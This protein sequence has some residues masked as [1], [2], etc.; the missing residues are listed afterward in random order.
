VSDQTKR[1]VELEEVQFFSEDVDIN[2][3]GFAVSEGAFHGYSRFHKDCWLRSPNGGYLMQIASLFE[4][5]KYYNV[6]IEFEEVQ[7]TEEEGPAS[8]DSTNAKGEQ[9]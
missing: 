6:K 8:L 5:G 1:T 3:D 9:K 7:P 2:T 4:H